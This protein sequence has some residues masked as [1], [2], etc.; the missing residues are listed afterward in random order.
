MQKNITITDEVRAVLTA[1]VITETKLVLPE[2]PRLAPPLYKAVNKVI[3]LAGGT[4]NKKE[5]AHVFTS[6]PR[7]RL[8]LAIAT[9]TQKLDIAVAAPKRQAAAKKKELQAFYTPAALAARVVELADVSGKRVLEPSAGAGALAKECFA[10]GAEQ[11]VAVEIDTET[12]FQLGILKV[13][14]MNKPGVRFASYEADFLK[15][16]PLRDLPTVD[17]VVMN[18]P[19]T[20]GLD[21]KH[22]EHALRFLK[23]D[24]VLVAVMSATAPTK[25]AFVR[26]AA[27]YPYEVFDVEEGA[28]R[29]SGTNVST[30]IV[31][32]TNRIVG[33]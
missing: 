24:G 26:F 22:V 15:L 31:R 5:K 11:V 23:P 32:I 17:R 10:Q 27:H 20:K 16:V 9:G 2:S 18:P 1:S 13:P 30:V 6:D 28:F 25:D 7:E 8:G 19:F 33:A 12:F 14:H 3:E 29:E 21:I 4:W